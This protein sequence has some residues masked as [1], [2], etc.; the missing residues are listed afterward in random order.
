VSISI[1]D[2]ETFLAAKTKHLAEKLVEYREKNNLVP[3]RGSGSVA[4]ISGWKAL[5]RTAASELGNH[6]L[7]TLNAGRNA[8]IKLKRKKRN[9]EDDE[10]ENVRES[11]VSLPNRK[12]LHPVVI[13]RR[14]E[15]PADVQLYTPKATFSVRNGEFVVV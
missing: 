15:P 1:S 5:V 9:E 6:E 2:A 4:S 12:A 10:D 7:A 11:P 14:I 8:G 13:R 3:L